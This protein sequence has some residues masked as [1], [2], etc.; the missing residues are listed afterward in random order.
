V[1][2]ISD[3]IMHALHRSWFFDPNAVNV[4]AEG[5]KVRLR[6]T[7]NSLHERQVAASTAWSAPGVTDVENDLVV[8]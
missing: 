8:R 5:S 3:D 7:V 2:N 4:T 1:S 6:G